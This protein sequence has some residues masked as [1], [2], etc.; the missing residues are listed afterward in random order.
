MV[1]LKAMALDKTMKERYEDR[2]IF[3]EAVCHY[4]VIER[5]RKWER[6]RKEAHWECCQ[7][8]LRKIKSVASQKPN[9]EHSFSEKEKPT[10]QCCRHSNKLPSKNDHCNQQVTCW[11]WKQQLQGILGSKTPYPTSSLSTVVPKQG[12]CPLVDICQY[13]EKFSSVMTWDRGRADTSI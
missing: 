6:T 3:S 5:P 2:N 13:L 12:V 7:W 9:E 1:F 8:G 4:H 10:D 11:F